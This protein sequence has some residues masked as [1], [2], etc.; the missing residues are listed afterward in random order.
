MMMKQEAYKVVL[1]DILNNGGGMFVG[2]YD[3]E[4]GSTEF[5]YGISAVME[6]LA[7]SI[8]EEEGD[9]FSD[10]FTKNMVES[11]RKAQN[12]ELEDY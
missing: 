6:Y 8:C 1:N 2:K 9:A 5:M 10:T 12:D 4:N 3:A 11:K 7:Y